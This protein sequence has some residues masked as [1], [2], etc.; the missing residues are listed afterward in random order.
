MEGWLLIE[1]IC[2]QARWWTFPIFWSVS[3]GALLLFTIRFMQTGLRLALF[4]G[5]KLLA[6]L[7]QLRAQVSM[8]TLSDH[9]IGII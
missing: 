5:E 3:D 9:L 2:V 7:T 1:Y 8:N 4:G 6:R